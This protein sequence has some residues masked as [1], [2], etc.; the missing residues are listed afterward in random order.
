MWDFQ[1]QGLA[2]LVLDYYGISEELIPEVAQTFSVQGE[3]TKDAAGELGLA[4]GTV[5][6]YRAGDQPN[7]ALSLNVL[8][9]GE[10]AATAGTSG[11]VYGISDKPNH[12]SK[13]RVNTFVHVNYVPESPRYGVLL[14]LNGAGILN[15]WLRQNVADTLSYKQMNELA[16]Q[17]PVGCE[18]LA[19]LPY[20]N[21]AERTLENRDIGASVYGLNFNI[22]SRAH[23]LRAAQEGIVFA[24]NYG[25]GI[26]RNVGVEV[27][28]VRAGNA[29][30][31]LSPLFSE[32]FAT[33][34]ESVVELY[35]TDGSQGSARG[36]GIGAGIYQSLE[37]A[38]VGLNP[39]ETIEPDEK[40]APAYRQAYRRWEGILRYA[41]E[42]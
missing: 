27:R 12:D 32:A 39:I 34:T 20:G 3:L 33:V 29:N 19:I 13:S 21:G 41:Q 37:E 22:H 35:N 14:C 5:V 15:S 11:V 38:F 9:P 6:S 40:L 30:M 25:L 16:V 18:G 17:V 7:N 8:N 36:A 42:G 24:L 10:I 4:A 28:T 31:F 1:Q 26:M 23:L 2:R